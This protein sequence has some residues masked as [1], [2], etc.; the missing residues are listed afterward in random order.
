LKYAAPD[1]ANLREGDKPFLVPFATLSV[2]QLLVDIRTGRI[3][4]WDIE[5]G[6]AWRRDRLW[7]SFTSAL[8]F[9]GSL[10]ASPPPWIAILP[11]DDEWE[12]T[13]RD[14]DFPG[15]LVGTEDPV[16]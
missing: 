9:V 4:E 5:Q 14:P 10:L 15:T 2:I 13:N 12:V 1:D 3:G 8:D 6:F 11:G 7:R 16:D